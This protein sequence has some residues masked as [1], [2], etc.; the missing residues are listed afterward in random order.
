MCDPSLP[1]E[2]MAKIG[3]FLVSWVEEVDSTVGG[4]PDVYFVRDEKGITTMSKDKVKEIYDNAKQISKKWSKLL[5]GLVENPNLITN[6]P[7]KKL[8][9]EK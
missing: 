5:P 6:S 2:K 1:I 4:I 9:Q 7:P 8:K 3:V